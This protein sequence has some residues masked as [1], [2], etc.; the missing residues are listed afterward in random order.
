MESTSQLQYPSAF[1]CPGKSDG[2]VYVDAQLLNCDHH[3]CFKC[4]DEIIVNKQPCPTCKKIVAD[5]RPDQEFN[6][7]VRCAL[8][9][10]NMQKPQIKESH[11]IEEIKESH[12][13]EE[14]V[15]YPFDRGNFHFRGEEKD[16]GDI[17]ICFH[18]KQK[19]RRID[20][21][22]YIT[23]RNEI[24]VIFADKLSISVFI[25]LYMNNIEFFHDGLFLLK[26]GGYKP[27]K[28]LISLLLQNNDFDQM[29][30]KKIN[31]IEQ[32]INEWMEA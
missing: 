28:M 3:V 6:N 5:F 17:Y 7:V 10:L 30:A 25:H 9:I 1:I 29:A 2:H 22:R 16:Y 14:K 15:R 27:V 21:I 11:K 23:D 8:Q 20:E 18:N 12:K 13:I 31:L 24:E 32:K 4:A 26:V 19:N